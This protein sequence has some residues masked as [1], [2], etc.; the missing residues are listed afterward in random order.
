MRAVAAVAILVLAS[1]PGQLLAQPASSGTTS[2]SPAIREL[3]RLEDQWAKALISRDSGFF[4]RTLHPNYVYSDERGT[5]DK[6]QVIA[7]QVGGTDTVQYA[8]NEDMR[9]H[10]YGAAAV[11]TGVL[12]VRGRGRAGTFAHRY[13]FTDTWAREGGHWLMVASQDYDIPR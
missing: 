5:F 4:R 2:S 13:R 8:A 10:V 9:A 3:F 1:A 12:V 6:D 11:V 7:E